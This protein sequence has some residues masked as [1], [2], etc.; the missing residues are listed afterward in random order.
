[1]T[2]KSARD[3]DLARVIACCSEQLAK[4]MVWRSGIHDD[5][6]RSIRQIANR[7]E[8]RQWIDHLAGAPSQMTRNL[9]RGSEVRVDRRPIGAASRSRGDFINAIG[10]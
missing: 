5:E 2:V 6:H 4:S 9:Q 1:L 10:Q 3:D 8:A 7:D